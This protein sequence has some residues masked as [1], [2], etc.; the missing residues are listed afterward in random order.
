MK[1]AIHKEQLDGAEFST[2]GRDRT[3]GPTYSLHIDTRI[4][5]C[6]GETKLVLL[7]DNQSERLSKPDPDLIKAV[8][9]AHAWVRQ[10]ISGEA[11]NIAEIARREGTSRP[12]ASRLM[13]LAF[14]APDIVEAILEGRQPP[15]VNVEYL[16]KDC[17][18]PLSWE[19]QRRV[20]GFS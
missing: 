4:K 20:L 17:R 9:K 1:A 15:E 16:T 19:D 2:A 7:G 11:S 18:L 6:G 8:A 13:N 14:L 12:H 3:I 5:R 10:L